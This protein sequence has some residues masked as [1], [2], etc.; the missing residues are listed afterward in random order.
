MRERQVELDFVRGLALCLMVLSHTG[1]TY[2]LAMQREPG[3]AARWL[4]Q[5]GETAPA[6]FFFAFGMTLD[7]L[8]AKAPTII[9]QRLWLFFCV[10]MVH[11]ALLGGLVQLDF[12]AFL[13][14]AQVT[15]LAIERFLA[16]RSWHYAVAW[17]GLLASMLARPHAYWDEWFRAIVPGFFPLVPWILF[18]VAGLVYQRRRAARAWWPL[19][20]GLVVLSL[21]IALA[22]RWIGWS[23]W[24]FNKLVLTGPYVL[25]LTGCALLCCE[26]V[27]SFPD[28]YQRLP[29]VP[30]LLGFLS[31]NLLLG[32]V[33]HYL[34][35]FG[36][37]ALEHAFVPIPVLRER[38]TAGVVLTSAASLA[39]LVL[40]VA[41]ARR[42][43]ERGAAPPFRIREEVV[44]LLGLLLGMLLMRLREDALANPSLDPV[45]IRLLYTL[46]FVA[47]MGRLALGL[48][49]SPA[50]ATP[51]RP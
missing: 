12:L 9:R 3:E 50:R 18:V 10:A 17:C 6:W 33:L 13:W 48:A 23:S 31:R 24:A 8:R 19:G 14:L 7:Q 16:P 26:A 38:H 36:F 47:V 22:Q 46:G 32:T 51:P 41:F 20:V 4:W 45:A 35:L 29:V 15:L 27:R 21:S 42:W 2:A 49:S 11:N 1:V 37:F 28:A 44:A 39:C 34:P 5:I 30:R 40:L 25:L 43:W